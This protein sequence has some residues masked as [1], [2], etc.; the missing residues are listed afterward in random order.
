MT[1]STILDIWQSHSLTLFGRVLI[2]KCLGISQL[3][4]SLSILETPSEYIKATNSLLFKSI[5]KNSKTKLNQKLCLLIV[6]KTPISGWSNKIVQKL[7][8]MLDYFH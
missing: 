2:T 4:Y 6:A 8:H 3:V 1:L 5:C 7:S